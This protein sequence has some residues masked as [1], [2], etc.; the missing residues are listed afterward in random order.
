MKIRKKKTRRSDIKVMTKEAAVLKHLRES[1]KFSLRKASVMLGLSEAKLNHSENGRCDLNPKLIL[2]IITG[3]GYGYEEFMKLV[4]GDK[5]LPS[6]T[7]AECV[8]I[9][10]R[11]DK[12]KLKTVKAILE[13]F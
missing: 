2:K 8:E 6:N 9:L 4:K 11:L 3:Y 5:E 1:R 7:Y 10:K 13:S 12:E